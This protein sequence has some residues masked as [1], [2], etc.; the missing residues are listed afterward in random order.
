[1]VCGLSYYRNQT[2]T[3][4][5]EST[6]QVYPKQRQKHVGKHFQGWWEQAQQTPKA[7]APRLNL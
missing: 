6:T 3:K 1:M 7:G 2:P 5:A 4:S